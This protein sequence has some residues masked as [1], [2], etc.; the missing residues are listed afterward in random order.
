MS[1]Q[2][3]ILEDIAA[4]IGYS[5]TTRLVGWYGGNHMT[6]PKSPPTSGP[7][8]E[9][10]GASAC[11]RLCAEFPG[12]RIDVP[13]DTLRDAMRIRRRVAI[14]LESGIGIKAVSSVVGI[15]RRQVE[16]IRETLLAQGILSV[17]GKV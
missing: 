11:A 7:L 16:R 12:E 17:G 4:V 3:T 14:L 5:A 9:L 15:P 10:L 1:G 8:F 13:N 6:V 2:N